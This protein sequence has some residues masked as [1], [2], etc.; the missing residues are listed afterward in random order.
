VIGLLQETSTWQ[1]TTFTRGRH[2]CSWR[3]WNPQ[4]QQASGQRT[5]TLHYVAT[6]IGLSSI[7]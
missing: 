6:E 3:D 2:P 7:Y 1:Y 5:H 4:S